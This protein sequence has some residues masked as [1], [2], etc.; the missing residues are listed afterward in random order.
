MALSMYQ[1]SVPVFVRM[2]GNLRVILERGSAYAESR[3]FDA[4]LLA[5]SRLFADMFPLVRQVQ[6]ATDGAKGCAARLAGI[7]P[8]KF[9]DTEKTM[10]DILAR[11]DKTIAF[12]NSVKAEQVD[13]SEDRPITLTLRSGELKFDGQSFLLNF[14]LPN[15]YF[16]I[17]TTYNIL[18][19]NGVEIGKMDYL[20]RP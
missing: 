18:R 10:S 14:A 2:L 13:G 8:P 16:H 3:K 20:G 4:T 15:F 6:I 11:I 7:E 19:H 5:D 12:L 9:D 1:A 17:T